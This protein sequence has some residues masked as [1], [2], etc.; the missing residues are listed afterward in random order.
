MR[1]PNQIPTFDSMN[2][3]LG[4]LKATQ[5]PRARHSPEGAETIR[6]RTEPI[7][8][9]TVFGLR[10]GEGTQSQG[11]CESPYPVARA[12]QATRVFLK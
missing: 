11:C 9:E 5:W 3:E 10:N 2:G 7:N 4:E 6:K 1:E 8:K 12:V